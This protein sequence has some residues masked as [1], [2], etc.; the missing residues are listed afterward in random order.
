MLTDA[1]KRQ[2]FDNGMDPLDA[3]EQAQQNQGYN[4]FHQHHHHGG[5]PFGGGGGGGG[6]QF[7]FKFN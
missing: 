7:K 1:E 2:K 4:P 6:F 3:E 5:G